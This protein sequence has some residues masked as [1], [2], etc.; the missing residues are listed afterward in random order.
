MT[1]FALVALACLTLTHLN[2]GAANSVDGGDVGE[3]RCAV[4]RGD[5]PRDESLQYK[6]VKTDDCK[7]LVNASSY[8]VLLD[9]S[10]SGRLQ[11]ELQSLS[12][13]G[14]LRP[15]SKGIVL[16]LGFQCAQIRVVLT[17]EFKTYTLKEL[18]VSY[19]SAGGTNGD[20]VS[21]SSEQT[22]L[23]FP[24]DRRFSCLGRLVFNCLVQATDE[25]GASYAQPVAAIV[26]PNGLELELGGEPELIGKNKFSMEPYRSS[27]PQ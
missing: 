14:D 4:A 16:S 8:L 20:T 24:S 27:C 3:P 17:L 26:F 10:Q 6:L 25:A 5:F 2:R 1:R 19:L 22:G 12:Q 18:Q 7:T 13:R 15:T 11:L 23:S 9:A 21:C